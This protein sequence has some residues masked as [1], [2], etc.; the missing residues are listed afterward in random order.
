[1]TKGLTWAALALALL[2]A[3][4]LV[5]YVLRLARRRALAH[6]AGTAPPADSGPV[7]AAAG[8]VPAVRAAFAGRDEAASAAYQ[9]PQVLLVGPRGAAS[10]ALEQ[11]VRGD[12][13]QALRWHAAA[14]GW[15]LCADMAAF[16]FEHEE[17]AQGWLALAE[18][19]ERRRPRRPLDGILL[20][21]PASALYGPQA[22]S[23][24][25]LERR[26]ALARVRL[27]AL[28]R[29]CGLRLPLYLLVTHCAQLDGFTSF[30]A[31]LPDALRTAMLGWSNPH[32][33][34]LAF[35]PAWLHA[36]FNEVGRNISHLQAELA[37]AGAAIHDSD[38]FFLLP[39]AIARLAGP[40]TDYAAR[41]LGEDV[42]SIAPMLR[43]VYLCGDAGSVAGALAGQP[44]FAG[45]LLTRK[46]FPERGLAS[47]LGGQLVSRN[48]G[49]RRWASACAVV[50][51]AWGG[52]LAWGHVALQRQASQLTEAVRHIA[53][54]QERRTSARARQ[55]HMEFKEYKDAS[56][57]ILYAMLG[58][59]GS[60]SQLAIPA[61]WQWTGLQGLD[62]R[63]E[64]QFGQGLSNIVYRTLE[65]GMNEVAANQT[66]AALDAAVIELKDDVACQVSANPQHSDLSPGAALAD[67]TAFK[68]L[69]RYVANAG[70]FEQARKEL[71]LLYQ[72]Q[73]GNLRDLVNVA[74]YTQAFDMPA[75]A[76]NSPSP[77]LKAVLNQKHPP[78]N[79]ALQRARQQQS[80][81]CAFHQ[82]HQQFLASM[83]DQHPALQAAH[84]VADQ[85]R[86]GTALA[87]A[88]PDTGLIPALQALGRWL[89]APTLH[90]LDEAEVAEGKAYGE[91]LRKV[92]AN[93]LLGPDAA[94]WARQQR[95]EHVRSLQQQLLRPGGTSHAV[96]QRAS[97]GRLS[98]TP[99]LANL[100][101]GLERLSRQPF[102]VDA[103][104]AAALERHGLG[105]LWDE[106]KLSVALLQA[107]EGR[108]YLDKE[109][110]SFPAP[111]QPEL[112][113]HTGQRL[114]R[115]LLAEAS[116]SL[117]PGSNEADTYQQLGRVQKQLSSLLDILAGLDADE[118]HR[119]LAGAIALQAN[120][121]L[122]WLE[123]EL[124]AGGL[125]LPR[126]GGFDWWQGSPNPAAQAFSGGDPQGLEDYLV[127]QQ[128][129]IEA[130]VRQAQPLL[131]LVE[132]AQGSLSSTPARHWNAISTDLARFQD[133]QPN[134][135]MAQLHAY[136]RGELASADG[137]KCQAGGT[138]PVQEGV[139][140]ARVHMAAPATTASAGDLFSERRRT[141]AAALASR[142]SALAR[143]DAEQDY[144]ALREQFRR[145]LAGRF[146]F[147]DAVRGSEPAA[148]DDVLAYLQLYDQ[149]APDSQRMA[150][151]RARDFMAATTAA[152]Q[153]LGPLLPAA[154]GAESAGYQLAVRFRV[155]S[156]GEADG[157]NA[158][159]GEIG[160][161]R[162]AA[163]SLQSGDESIG[164][165]SGSKGA[166][167]HL[168]W[169]PGLPL[170]LTLRWAD[171]VAELPF[172]DGHD[173]Y[174]EVAGRR[175]VYRFN[176]PWSLM[177]LLARHATPAQG[178]GRPATLRFDLPTAPGGQGTRVF[179]RL[180][181]MAANRKETLAFP[182][183]PAAAPGDDIP[184]LLARP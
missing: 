65:K 83:V 117:P 132:A 128:A 118:Q 6:A 47:P 76:V 48:K 62:R 44:W 97:D 15:I 143:A 139:V 176:E 87:S 18:E 137:R 79:A 180:A 178:A 168:A 154:E 104:P 157:N 164:Y 156:A 110:P 56:Q 17:G 125:Y 81:L 80:I 127:A 42:R 92:Q 38:A 184:R 52:A 107:G 12:D 109:I 144:Q 142:C 146:P 78:D 103:G 112:R 71:D 183:F 75:D 120:E 84:S 100:Q 98:L 124:V 23:P 121:G 155:G 16:G 14:Q 167:Q 140:L 159:A 77:L 7:A 105:P 30:A 113:R 115:Y 21:I 181:V 114:A 126:D 20:A 59:Q 28:Q 179:M 51:L 116:A 50:L 54:E 24:L 69:E 8:L 111:F 55:G 86:G 138:L 147:A 171:N 35:A 96:L 162:I 34:E 91:L 72:Q 177:R 67:T 173:R 64:A 39:G 102:M 172:D 9:V 161:N 123:R 129:R 73:H 145:T 63:I 49:V 82:Q 160:G 174:L 131:R 19:L 60:L 141:L 169:R 130:A 31:A 43:G 93:P 46:V 26:A 32:D 95:A 27:D 40:A 41:L 133:K 10:S 134:A 136:I 148:L 88:E 5:W 163:W 25:E 151:G 108:S 106:K 1:M 3:L 70:V 74:A 4:L 165:D 33:P 170:V 68:R 36:A 135:R 99:E 61:S 150:P 122:R 182:V 101:A 158:L 149:L 90:W 152:R 2:L 94:A 175:A 89:Q 57:N 166:V 66:G 13:E 22:W 85:L 53:R 37:A 11:A 119:Q 153:F 58:S 45:D 29:R